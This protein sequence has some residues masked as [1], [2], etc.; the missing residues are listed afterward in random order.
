MPDASLTHLAMLLDRS[1]SMQSIKAATEEGFAAFLTEQRQSPGRC[2]VT[3]AQ[4]DQQYDEVYTDVDVHSAPAL[5]LKPRGMTALLDS[6]GRLVQSTALRIAQL[7]EEQRPANVVVGI[8]TDGLEN[9]SKEYTHAAVKALVSEREEKFG[10]TFL[11]MG[12]NQDAIEVGAS[13]GVSAD[14]SLTYEAENVGRAYAATSRAL[15]DVRTAVQAGASP[16]EARDLHVRYSE[17]ERRAA[18]PDGAGSGG[19]GSKARPFSEAELLDHLQAWLRTGEKAVANVGT[20]GGRAV[21]HAVVAGQPVYINADTR[22]AAVQDLVDSAARG[23]VPWHVLAN[24]KGRLDKV[25][26]RSDGA[27]APG[28]YCYTRDLQPAAGRLGVSDRAVRR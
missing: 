23:P 18:G 6:I 24:G 10:W 7:P 12:A 15:R 14:R 26:F 21:L 25:T 1:G 9:A 8:M 3:L 27:R 4:F 13:I 16:A 2:T 22:R 17:A 11:Y 19:D 20:Y 5:D 28:F